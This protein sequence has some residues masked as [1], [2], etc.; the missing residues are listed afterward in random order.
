MSH[1]GFRHDYTISWYYQVQFAIVVAQ[2]AGNSKEVTKIDS[3]DN[4]LIEQLQKGVFRPTWR[5]RN[6]GRSIVQPD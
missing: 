1:D 2:I 4:R 5:F 3:R 6:D